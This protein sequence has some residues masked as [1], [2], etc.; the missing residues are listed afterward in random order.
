MSQRVVALLKKYPEMI[1]E[2][3]VLLG[4]IA[5][6]TGMQ[7]EDVIEAMNFHQPEGERVQSSRAYDRIERIAMEYAERLNQL[8][9]DWLM[10]L[11]R[12][13]QSLVEEIAFFE[14]A[15]HALPEDLR[16][17]MW[18]IAT[19]NMTWECIAE[20]H[21]ISRSSIGYK[22]KKAIEALDR[23]YF[24]RNHRYADYVQG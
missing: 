10:H 15:I 17:I 23:L 18:D 6:F 13:Y 16:G 4:E 1:R 14:K 19:S 22:R 11:Q 20:K 5:T 3:N 8:N 24:N 2:R 12:R 9:R 7:A 21:N